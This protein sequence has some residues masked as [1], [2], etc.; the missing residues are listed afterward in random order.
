MDCSFYCQMVNNKID[1]IR[2]SFLLTGVITR[3]QKEWLKYHLKKKEVIDFAVGIGVYDSLRPVW[4]ISYEKYVD[5]MNKNGKRPHTNKT[6]SGKK[7]NT[8]YHWHLEQLKKGDKLSQEK[9][10]L[11]RRIKIS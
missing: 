9:Q 10:N 7:E 2:K 1:V 6:P 4:D 11:L 3:R 5:F 8:L